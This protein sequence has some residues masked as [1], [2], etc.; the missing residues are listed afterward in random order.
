MIVV[1]VPNF[2]ILTPQIP[3]FTRLRFSLSSSHSP[4]QGFRSTITLASSL[5]LFSSL[6]INISNNFYL[7]KPSTPS[8]IPTFITPTTL[9]LSTLSLHH[10][11]TTFNN[12]LKPSTS[13]SLLTPR[14]PLSLTSLI[15]RSRSRLFCE[16][17]PRSQPLTP[18]LSN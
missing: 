16:P 11:S 14:F 1:R 3:F 17:E 7:S 4:D 10:P 6:T 15:N 5:S 8:T 12:P 18:S 2:L 9:K 13:T